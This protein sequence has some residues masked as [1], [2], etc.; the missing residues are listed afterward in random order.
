MKK[1]IYTIILS[2]VFGILFSACNDD[3]GKNIFPDKYLKILS[4]KESGVIYLRMNTTQENVVDSILILKGGGYPNSIANMELKILTREEAAA[5]GGFETD[6]VQIIP[7]EG[8]EIV[9]DENI[10]IEPEGRYKYIP[11]MFNPLAIYTAMKEHDDDV[12]WVLPIALE[13]ATDTVNLGMDKILY[14]VDV[15][16]PLVD[17]TIEDVSS[18]EITYLSLDYPVSVELTNSETNILDF[19]C[20]LDVSQNEQLVEAYNLQNGTA[21]NLLPSASYSVDAFIFNAGEKV[22]NSNLKLTRTGLESDHSYLLPLKLGSLSEASIDKTDEVRY[23]VVAN[24]KYSIKEVSKN[25]WKIVFTNTNRDAPRLIDGS[26]ETA[27]IIPWWTDLVYTDD[28]NY[29]F[30]EYHAFTRR[31]DMPNAA[32]IVDFGREISFAGIGIGQGTLDMGDRDLKDCEFYLADTFTFTPDGDLVNYNTVEKGN[33]W[34]HAITCTNI[35]NIGGGPYWY[36]L[37]GAELSSGI[38]KGRY[39]KIRPTGSHRN[40]PKL[41]SFSEVYAKEIVAIDGV[42]LK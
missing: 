39:L 3:Y 32:I 22:A 34:E 6:K 1:I 8:F 26:L 2:G 7:S 33:T 25:N 20:E 11:I 31:R 35:S 9:G 14:R 41:C 4:L 27:W 42:A 28:Y 38:T 5:F 40:D 17:W 15:R 13:S 21:Y 24:P 29:D 37:S 12:V 18:T 36:D 30:T 16:S 10:K 23:L 19:T